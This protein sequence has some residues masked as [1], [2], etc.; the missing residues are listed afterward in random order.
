VVPEV[1]VGEHRLVVNIVIGYMY[2]WRTPEVGKHVLVVFE[3]MWRNDFEDV[4]LVSRS[5][6]QDVN[7]RTAYNL[8]VGEAY[9]PG[10]INTT[11]M[12]GLILK[13]SFDHVATA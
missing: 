10:K 5:R 1:F 7:L 4:L 13:K 8:V 12:T 11:L 3:V 2:V 9:L 6:C